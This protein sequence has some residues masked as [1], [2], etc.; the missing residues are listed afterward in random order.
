MGNRQRYIM[1]N[2]IISF[3]RIIICVHKTIIVRVLKH[4]IWAKSKVY[5]PKDLHNHRVPDI[6]EQKNR[7]DGHEINVLIHHLHKA[8]RWTRS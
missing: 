5:R 6:Y 2:H 7:I 8:G 4:Q 1:E 3:C